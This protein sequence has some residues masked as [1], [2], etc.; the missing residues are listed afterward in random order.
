MYTHPPVNPGSIVIWYTKSCIAE[1][2]LITLADGS[3]VAVENLTGN[4]LLL[5]WN[6]YT[7]S[8][9]VAP[10]LFI[11]NDPAKTYEII[12]L[13]FSDGTDVKIISEH[14][15]WNFNLNKYVYLRN[16]AAQYIGHWFN[17]LTS[18]SGNNGS[19][20]Y[21]F[22]WEMVQLVDVEIYAEY[23][24][25]WSPVTFSH[26]CYYV[27]GMLSM[28]GN[29]ESLVNFFEVDGTTMQINQAAYQADIETYGLFT[30][31]EFAAIIPV[32]E[33]VFEAFDAQYFKVA[34]GKGLLD[35]ETV[36]ALIEAYAQFFENLA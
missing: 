28:P 35:W 13:Y 29:T 33:I 30:Y 26:L 8:F 3:Q 21:S 16:D 7:G 23:T 2:T 22:N 1:G 18:V 14:G 19:A 12:H 17:K 11:D 31:E 27:N 36:G 34:M 4:E 32:S 10:I 15:F 20:G 25:A 6:L 9:D 5:V 24:T